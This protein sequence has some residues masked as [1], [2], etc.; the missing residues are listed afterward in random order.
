MSSV[1]QNCNED[2]GVLES[3]EVC[4]VSNKK[5]TKKANSNANSYRDQSRSDS[6][7]KENVRNL[8]SND[9]NKERRRP[10]SQK[11]KIRHLRQKA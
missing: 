9:C 1:Q 5:A 11:V 3:T 4:N 8:D 10:G 7:Q 2:Q 6:L